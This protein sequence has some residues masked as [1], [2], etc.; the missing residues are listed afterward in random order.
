MLEF[1]VL[2]HQAKMLT[3]ACGSA[4]V[5]GFESLF[6]ILQISCLWRPGFRYYPGPHELQSQGTSPDRQGNFVVDT[7]H[8]TLSVVCQ[9]AKVKQ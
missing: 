6:Y 4:L 9:R 1:G 5:S 2:A 3:H 8:A 7:W